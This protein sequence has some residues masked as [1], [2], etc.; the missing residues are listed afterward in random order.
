MPR[1]TGITSVGGVLSVTVTLKVAERLLF[2]ESAAEQLTVRVPRAKVEPDAGEHETPAT[3][4]STRSTATGV[5]KLT[6]EPEGPFASTVKSGETLCKFGPVVST[7]LT[8][9][10]AGAEGL[11]DASRAV[12]E[13]VVF[14]SGNVCPDERLHVTDGEGSMVSDAVTE[15]VAAAPLGPVASRE[16]VPGT[17]TLG[18]PR[19]T[20][21]T[22]NVAGADVLPAASLAVQETVV[23]PI[24]KFAPGEWLHRTV[25][26]RSMASLAVTVN[27]TLAPP[28]PVASAVIGP[29]T[30]TVGAL[31]STRVMATVNVPVPVLPAT[32]LALQ[33]TVVV[34]RAKLVPEPGVQVTATD[35]STLSFALGAAQVTTLP[36]GDSV[37]S[38]ISPGTPLRTGAVV[39]ANVITTLN[40]A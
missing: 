31:K 6:F 37:F 22:V 40:V 34:P 11:F 12:H 24:G 15:N 16:I 21:L 28:G 5:G 2:L 18:A 19:S 35:P 39:S 23:V 9:K 20:T 38:A 29:G 7:T 30:E 27:A 25:G 10:V 1:E 17:E 36:P 13:T 32:S 8:T 14:P 33:V 4:P 26:K 3:G